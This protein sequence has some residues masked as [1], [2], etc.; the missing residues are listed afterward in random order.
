[1]GWNFP[2]PAEALSVVGRTWLVGGDV[3]SSQLPAGGAIPF[4]RR[5]GR[6]ACWSGSGP[7]VSAII[8]CGWR[9]DVVVEAQPAREAE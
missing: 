7:G 9:C 5:M 1:M 4:T 6:S 8:K 2:R 3:P